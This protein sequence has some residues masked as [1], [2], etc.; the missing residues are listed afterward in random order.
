MQ[1]QRKHILYKSYLISIGLLLFACT[2]VFTLVKI[3]N[4]PDQKK[5]KQFAQETTL[6][7][8]PLKAHRGNIYARDGSLLATSIIQYDVYIDL[9]T[10]DEK[11]FKDN[12]H[13]LSDSIGRL[14]GKPAAGFYKKLSAEKK[15]ENQYFL[16]AKGLDHVKCRRLKQFPILSK[17]QIK[18]GL[19]IQKKEVRVHPIENIG[20][21]TIGYDDHR[22][23]AGFEGAY[24]QWLSGQNGKRLEQRISF[25]AWKP[26]NVWNEVEPQEGKDIY[27]TIDIGM[28]DIAYNALV[29]QLNIS[30]ADH[31]S[32]VLMEVKTGE[33]HAMVNL[34]KTSNRT[35]ENRRNFA[36]WEANE[37]GSTFKTIALLAAIEDKKID[38]S[39]QVDT[40]GGVYILYGKKVRDDNTVGY[41]II[42][43]K[44]TLE[45]SS[46]VG[47]AKLI[48]ENYKSQPEKFIGYLKNWHLDKKLDIDIPGEGRP[49]IPEPNGKRWSK[50][51]L[52]WMSFG[53]NLH[54]TP[55]QILNFYNAIAN[56][57]K[58]VKPL[59]I[60]E[61]KEEGRIIKK[62]APLVTH[63]MIAS[64]TSIKKIQDLLENVVQNGTVKKYYHPQYPYA[65]KTGT[66]R[67]NYWMSNKER[68][69]NSFF[70]GYFPANQPK[71][72]CIVVISKPKNGYYGSDTAAPVFNKIAQ[73][74]YPK[75]SRKTP[76]ISQKNLWEKRRTTPEKKLS[77]SITNYLPDLKGRSGKE[78]IAI[79]ENN[80]LRVEYEGIGKILK[81]SIPAG[82]KIKKG[83]SIYLTLEG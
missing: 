34:E 9:K 19:I 26:L 27:S 44:K 73:S 42:S 59:F 55:L 39:T 33:I 48:H 37:P 8:N 31:G 30:D 3:Q 63:P 53:Y 12:I 72:S 66:A 50:I 11:L 68:Y 41:G 32:V 69:Y 16:L 29:E 82:E 4:S 13:A 65:G 81:Q 54:M 35:Y 7:V 80:G 58:M 43:A 77:D 6:R 83:Q 28:Q 75:T 14:F 60:K 70:V 56:E 23:K 64:K 20:S 15:K 21:R 46:N 5:Y 10:I 71:Y 18:G 38:T 57:G 79:L 51:T 76:D 1:H 61:I 17:G 62:Y 52:P 45:V 25:N 47:M 24:S 67:L 74:I 40:K 49:Y 78:V 2:I 36:I 22:G